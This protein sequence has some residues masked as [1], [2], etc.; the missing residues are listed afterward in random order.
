MYLYRKYPCLSVRHSVTFKKISLGLIYS[1]FASW[2][3]F[4]LSFQVVRDLSQICIQSLSASNIEIILDI[5]SSVA[6]HAHDLNSETILLKKLQKV[7]S[8]LELSDP[9]M[10]HFENESY[11]NYL[12]FL[13]GLLRDNPF[14]SEMNTE[15]HLVE[16]CTKIL[17]I[18]LNCT[19]SQQKP[20][21]ETRAIHWILPL[22]SAKKEEVAARTSLLV[23]AL[24][25]LSDLERD[26]FRKYVSNFFPLLVDLV[27]SEHG[28]RE[29]PHLLGNMFKSCIGPVIMHW[30][31][32][33][34]IHCII[35]I[36][37]KT[38]HNFDG[39]FFS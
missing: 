26:S 5:L 7:C 3:Y 29:V 8:A 23:L 10:V 22:G 20:G 21:K 9:P 24:R 18:Y 19:V 1:V 34:Y 39:F 12:N 13:Q 36:N 37:N 25:M 15:S 31:Y 35:I 30:I 6:S 38:I 4:L 32:S 28:S 14:A 2:S 11:Q 16:V 17:R 27:R 33:Y